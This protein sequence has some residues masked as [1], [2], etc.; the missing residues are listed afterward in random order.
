[1][2]IKKKPASLYNKA[3]T[4]VFKSFYPGSAFKKGSQKF[5]ELHTN[6]Y[7]QDAATKQNFT[8]DVSTD[9]LLSQRIDAVMFTN[10]K[11]NLYDPERTYV[12]VAG[13]GCYEQ[14]DFSL[15]PFITAHGINVVAFNPLGIGKS[16]GA[17]N[18]PEDYQVALH[19]VIDKLRDQGV[20]TKNIILV[21]NDFGAGMASIVAD[22][23]Q[24]GG[25]DIKVMLVKDD[26][27]LNNIYGKSVPRIGGFIYRALVQLFGLTV[28]ATQAFNRMN[29]RIAG[30]ATIVPQS[31]KNTHLKAEI[32]IRVKDKEELEKFAKTKSELIKLSTTMLSDAEKMLSE[33]QIDIGIQAMPQHSSKLHT[34]NQELNA[35]YL[36]IR[37]THKQLD[38]LFGTLSARQLIPASKEQETEKLLQLSRQ[39]LT[40]QEILEEAASIYKQRETRDAVQQILDSTGRF[41]NIMNNPRISP[42]EQDNL[43]TKV[44]QQMNAAQQIYNQKLAEVKDTSAKAEKSLGEIRKKLEM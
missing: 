31:E 15:E 24:Q 40:L 38:K 1:M 25:H 21:G 35:Q 11:Q 41:A 26:A 2:P 17:T 32:E 7:S 37:S 43:L 14:M 27:K 39:V 36:H 18:G 10:N 20:D 44:K 6:F 23:Y 34:M 29:A 33:L 16:T 4:K 22:E 19:A 3:R 8:I 13:D 30:S 5:E 12:V 28:Q 42:V 9:E